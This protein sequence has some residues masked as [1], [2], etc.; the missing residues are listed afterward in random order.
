VEDRPAPFFGVLQRKGCRGFGKRNFQALSE[1]IERERE[2]P[3]N[4]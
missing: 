2:A 4:L 3:G 1:A